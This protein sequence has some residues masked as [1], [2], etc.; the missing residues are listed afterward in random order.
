MT[1]ELA[2]ER[3]QNWT[4]IGGQDC[5]P[6]DSVDRTTLTL[7]ARKHEE[8]R[9]ALALA[10]D[11]ELANWEH[12]AHQA[13]IASETPIPKQDKRYNKRTRRKWRRR[14]RERFNEQLW[15]KTMERRFLLRL[16]QPGGRRRSC[17]DSYASHQEEFAW[18]RPVCS[19]YRE[20]SRVYRANSAAA[21]W[22]EIVKSDAA[23]S[24]VRGRRRSHLAIPRASCFPRLP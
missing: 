22:S 24:M 12:I 2:I 6:F 11:C 15:I 10:K 5:G 18:R 3:G 16:R 14:W 17:W 13:L 23:T 8:F 4:P 21:R 1:D 19:P 7:W 9:K 20:P